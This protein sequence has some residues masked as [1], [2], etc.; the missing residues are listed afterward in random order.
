M[1]VILHP[2]ERN[3]A[4]YST[5]LV[6]IQ[7]VILDRQVWAQQLVRHHQWSHQRNQF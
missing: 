4:N 1:F 5:V 2:N 7:Q 3:S 6:N